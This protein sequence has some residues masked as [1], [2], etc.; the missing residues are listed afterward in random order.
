[1]RRGDGES[2]FCAGRTA[3]HVGAA[4]D[5]LA[6]QAVLCTARAEIDRLRATVTEQAVPD[7]QGGEAR[8]DCPPAWSVP[9]W[10]RVKAGPLDPP[11]TCAER[12]TGYDASAHAG[13][14][15]V[16]VT[17]GRKCKGRKSYNNLG[18]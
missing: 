6:E 14:S 2:A 9:E 18:G 15:G 7:L 5:V 12:V 3:R 11:L 10:T 4:A 1:V 13:A 16:D 17:S 8:W